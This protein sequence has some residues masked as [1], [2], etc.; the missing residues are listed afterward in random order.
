MNDRSGNKE[1]TAPQLV[2]FDAILPTT[3]AFRAEEAGVKRAALDPLTLFVLSVLAG[4]FIAFGAIF[5]TTVMAGNVT[6]TAPDGQVLSYGALPYGVVRLLAG[7]V[8]SLGLILVVIGGAELFT[9]NNMIVMAWAGGKIRTRDVVANWVIAFA[10]NAV[11]AFMTAVLTFYSTQYTFG[12]GA[13]GLAALTTA[14]AKTSLAFFPS[15]ILGILCNTLVC[16]AVW[17]CYSA[18][19]QHRSNFH[20]HIADRGF[21]GLRLRAQHRQYLFHSYRLVHRSGSSEFV[22]ERDRQNACG[23]SQ[24]DLEQFPVGQSDSGHHR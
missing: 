24:S 18:S 11:G 2:T 13:V 3:M 9:G 23:L 14:N 17:M 22:L 20:C 15:L 4:A 12:G 21:R 10:G 8:F 19:Q 1:P 16:L 5:A 7:L 6:I